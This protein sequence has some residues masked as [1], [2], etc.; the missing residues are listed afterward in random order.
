MAQEENYIRLFFEGIRDE[1]GMY[2]NTAT[3]IGTAFLLLLDYV[4][5]MEMPYLRKD[6]EDA[7]RDASLL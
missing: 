2:R 6:V 3:R 1:K 5:A 7:A 4:A